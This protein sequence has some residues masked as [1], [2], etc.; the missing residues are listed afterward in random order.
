VLPDRGPSLN[1][2]FALCN[3]SLHQ[4]ERLHKRLNPPSRF[5]TLGTPEQRR[6]QFEEDLQ[7]AYGDHSPAAQQK[8]VSPAACAP[9]PP[10]ASP[11]A[12]AAPSLPA[13]VAPPTPSL[14]PDS[15]CSTLNSKPLP[16]RD[17]LAVPLARSPNGLLTLDWSAARL[18]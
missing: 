14:G 17:V 11:V 5:K 18:V 13:A 15:P 3:R 2:L 12:P 9:S 8:G 7:R 10:P 4:I 6:R 16:K 1:S